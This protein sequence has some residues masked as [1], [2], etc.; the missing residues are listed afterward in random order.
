MAKEN[1]Q[2]KMTSRN[3]APLPTAASVHAVSE[4]S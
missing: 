4:G 1:C 2:S 3:E